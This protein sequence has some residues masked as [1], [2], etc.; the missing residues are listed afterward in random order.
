[1]NKYTT[2][3]IYFLHMCCNYITFIKFNIF[4]I[5]FYRTLNIIF[6]IYNCNINYK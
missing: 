3:D 4:I 2:F 5:S 6:M 1:M